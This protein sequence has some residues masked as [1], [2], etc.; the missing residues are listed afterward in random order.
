MNFHL[1]VAALREVLR[2]SSEERLLSTFRETG[3]QSVI[4]DHL[5]EGSS[6]LLVWGTRTIRTERM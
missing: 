1:F 3:S 2:H 4:S 5:L 6:F